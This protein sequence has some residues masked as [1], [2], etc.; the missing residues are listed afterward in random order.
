MKKLHLVTEDA[1]LD[2]LKYG[3][4]DVIVVAAGYEPRCTH[5]LDRLQRTWNVA[6]SDVGQKVILIEFDE[7]GGLDSRAIADRFFA[8]FT[9]RKR[10]RV[11]KDSPLGASHEFDEVMKSSGNSVR[12]ILID[13][14]AMS[15]LHYLTLIPLLADRMGVRVVFAYAVGR[16]DG[17]EKQ[18]PVATVGDPRAV[19]GL[20]GLPHSGRPRLYL[21]GLGYDGLGAEALVERLEAQRLAVFWADP[22]ASPRAAEIARGHNSRLIERARLH[23]ACSLWDVRKLTSILCRLAFETHATERLVFVP[24]GPKPHILACGLTAAQFEHTALL[25]P[26]F[27]AGGILRDVPEIEAAGDIILTRVQA[28][29]PPSYL[30]WL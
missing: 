16:Y 14:T 15:R 13:Y 10:I 21:F 6:P 5:V 18:Y 4:I 23:F 30:D 19:P 20:E 3:D 2:D 8:S 9:P 7:F 11:T 28:A 29:Q 24:I 22:G 27:D 25:A 26:H 12:N 17:L 1:S